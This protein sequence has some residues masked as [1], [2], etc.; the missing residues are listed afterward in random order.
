MGN[1][2]INC[3]SPIRGCGTVLQE[4][5]GLYL[6]NSWQNSP[7]DTEIWK[8]EFPI[9]QEVFYD[10]SRSDDPYY[11]VNPAR[12]KV[13]GNICVNKT[14]SIGNIDD[15]IAKYS[16]FSGNAAYTMDMLEAI[17]VDPAN[18]DYR[19]RED[20]VVYEIIPDFEQLP[21]EKMGRE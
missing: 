21:I 17:F 2:I 4:N 6:L 5:I 11:I 15:N 13:N 10:E 7:K 3:F 8:E 20:S 14:G 12:N 1:I 16:D 9:L 18:G 19:L